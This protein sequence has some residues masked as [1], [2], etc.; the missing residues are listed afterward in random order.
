MTAKGIKTLH[1]YPKDPMLSDRLIW[2]NSIDPDQTAPL[3]T[4]LLF[5]QT[6]PTD[7]V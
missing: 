6:A 1:I 4:R 3:Q 2:A 5:Y 7:A